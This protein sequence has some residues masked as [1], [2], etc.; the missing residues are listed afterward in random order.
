MIT[1]ARVRFA[2]L[3]DRVRS[4]PFVTFARL[5]PRAAG[6]AARTGPARHPCALLAAGA[7]L[8]LLASTAQAQ[9]GVS[10]RVDTPEFGIRIGQPLPRQVAPVIFAPAPMVVV[11]PQ[12][13]YPPVM[14]P[15]VVYQQVIYRPAPVP[16]FYGAPRF[17]YPPVIIAPPRLGPRHPHGHAHGRHKKRERHD[18]RVNYAD[19]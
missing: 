4:V 13:V 7:A 6:F 5:G 9:P 2:S 19:D 3:L 17:V 1:A 12:V 16:V 11:P 14:Y 10:V 8:S 18:S 15:P